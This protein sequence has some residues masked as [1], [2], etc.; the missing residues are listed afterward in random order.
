MLDGLD[1]RARFTADD[2]EAAAAAASD[3]SR[4]TRRAARRSRI[5]ARARQQRDFSIRA[6][7]DETEAVYRRVL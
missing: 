4:R 5:A 3:R 7:A 1:S 2:V 6:Q